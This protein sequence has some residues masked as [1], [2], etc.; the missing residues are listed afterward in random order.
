MLNDDVVSDIKGVERA[1]ILLLALG[2]EAASSLLSYMG[3]KEAYALGV[4]MAGLA[5]VSPD[6]TR[7]AL[8]AFVDSLETHTGLGIDSDIYVRNVLTKALGANKAKAIIDRIFIGCDSKSLEQLKWTDSRTIARM[9]GFEH[10]QI[11]AIILSFLDTDLAADVLNEMSEDVRSDIIQR[12][13]TLE[14]IQP[15]ALQELDQILEK[16]IA[17]NGSVKSS[18]HGGVKSAADILKLL[19]DYEV[20]ME[21]IAENDKNLAQTLQD[22]IFVFDDL[23]YVADRDIQTLLREI[24]PKQLQLALRKADDQLVEKIFNNMSKHAVEIMRN[25]IASADPARLKDVEAAQK[26]ILA[27][28]RRLADA[29]EITLGDAGGEEYI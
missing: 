22:T 25:D 21:K 27:T 26:Q 7:D 20:V 8:H 14:D 23:K 1:A 5:N 10:P 4:A 18:S 16:Q 2:E 17:D 9:I 19:N 28:A 11:I 15:S 29:G 6:Q 24:T 12:I 13:A 3:P